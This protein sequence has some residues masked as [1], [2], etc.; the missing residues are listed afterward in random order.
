MEGNRGEGGGKER[1]EPAFTLIPSLSSF[2]LSPY[3]SFPPSSLLP[4]SLSPPYLPIS[5]HYTFVC[6]NEQKTNYGVTRQASH[7]RTVVWYTA[8][9]SRELLYMHTLSAWHIILYMH[10]NAVVVP[11]TNQIHLPR[12]HHGT[13]YI[14][15]NINKGRL[16]LKDSS[17][18]QGQR[19]HIHCGNLVLKI[20]KKP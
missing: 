17:D 9:F 8:L 18:G 11:H 5:Y 3:P 16:L 12:H 15:G 19:H 7:P 6:M 1:C 20:R 14:N 2:S 4:L 13:C 10:L